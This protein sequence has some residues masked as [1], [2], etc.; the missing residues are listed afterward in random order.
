MDHLTQEYLKSRLTYCPDTGLLVWISHP[1]RKYRGSIAGGVNSQGYIWFE[2]D[3]VKYRAH[4][5]IWLYM[6]GTWPPEG[7]IVDHK[8]TIKHNNKWDNLRLATRSQNEC[9]KGLNS[10]NTSGIKGVCWVTSKQLWRVSIKLNGVTHFGGYYN[11]I[12]EASIAVQSLRAT[13]HKEFAR[14]T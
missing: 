9:N 7:Y 13:L 1:I 10:N 3:G 8:D 2:L 5:I 4:N 6:T 11:S 12:Q 14:H